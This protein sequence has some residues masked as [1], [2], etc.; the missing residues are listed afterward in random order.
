VIRKL[1]EKLG[2]KPDVVDTGSKAVAAIE[3]VA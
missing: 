1:L 2:L 3:A